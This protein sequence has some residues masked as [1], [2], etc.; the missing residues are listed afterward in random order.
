M[1]SGLP[2]KADSDASITDV[3]EVPVPV[4][5]LLLSLRQ[6]LRDLANAIDEKLRHRAERAVLERHDANRQMPARQFDGQHLE[7]RAL[8]TK[9][10]DGARN[11]GEKAPSCQQV[12]AQ[13]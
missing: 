4:I 6:W 10:Q 1:F 12:V 9:V 8:R 3:A 2:P 5:W 13:V 7:Q 11:H